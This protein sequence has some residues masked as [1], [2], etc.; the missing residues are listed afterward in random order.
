MGQVIIQ[1]NPLNAALNETVEHEGPLIDWVVERFPAGF[2]A[3]TLLTFN[4]SH[5]EIRDMDRVV[6]PEDEV[7]LL[8]EPGAPVAAWVASVGI[9]ALLTQAAVGAALSFGLSYVSNWLRGTPD[10]D[11]GQG[12][13]ETPSPT[14]SLTIPTNRARLG[15]VIPVIYGTVKAVP[16]IVAQPHRSYI[17][18]LPYPEYIFVM[19]AIGRGAYSFNREDIYIGDSS[20]GP[21][22]DPMQD[23]TIVDY[24]SFPPSRHTN[25]WGIIQNNCYWA[26]SDGQGADDGQPNGSWQEPAFYE[27]IETSI[28]VDGQEL[29]SAVIV[30]N[31]VANRA[32]SV[33]NHFQIDVEFP[34]GLYQANPDTGALLG[35]S[36]L[37]S[38]YTRLIDDDG[39]DLPGTTVTWQFT[40]GALATTAPVRYTVDIPGGA[41]TL[42]KGRYRVSMRRT[43]ADSTTSTLVNRSYWTG[44]RAVLSAYRQDSSLIPEYANVYE[45]SHIVVFRIKASEGIARDAANRISINAT[46]KLNL[47]S[48]LETDNPAY[49]VYDMFLNDIYGAGR[50]VSELDTTALGSFISQWNAMAGGFNAVYDRAT[51]LWPAMQQALRLGDATPVIHGGVVTVTQ[52]AAK[53][54]QYYFYPS[55]I[56]DGSVSTTYSLNDTTDYD[57]YEVEYLDT[58]S[59]VPQYVRY[60]T[61]GVIPLQVRY[62]GCTNKS[63]AEHQAEFLWFKRTFRRKRVSFT[64]EAIGNLPLVGD[65][66]YVE[67]PVV[68]KSGGEA[69]IVETIAPEGQFSV[70]IQG[71]ID[72]FIYSPIPTT[73]AAQLPAPVPLA[74]ANAEEDA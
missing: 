13:R 52:D 6:G 64:T 67:H 23:A 51:S 48:N 55:D 54:Y 30:G 9:G 70:T 39:N 63:M 66:I 18:N 73:T 28:E 42:S 26:N 37:F 29:R 15:E 68:T 43:T 2:P 19:M 69:Y 27:D 1:R 41:G 11:P 33:T 3:K 60:P 25:S 57:C 4:G 8:M 32:G 12:E 71:I 50:P 62:F 31:Y 59:Y 45:Y 22:A 49:I 17:N 38:V 16:D 10:A 5:L 40:V 21:A 46:R 35:A 44:L 47:S 56:V 74:G 7:Y 24:K 20:I 53:S 36:V 65:K 61:Y 58:E 34:N 72:N 14:Y